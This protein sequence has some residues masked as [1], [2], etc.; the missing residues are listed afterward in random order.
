MQPGIRL[1]Q[2]L[3]F[4]EKFILICL[5]FMIPLGFTSYYLLHD[6][7]QQ[8][9][10]MQQRQIGLAYIEAT[11]PLLEL[12]P[13]HRG[14]I[15]GLLHGHDA[16]GSNLAAITPRL[17]QALVM[18]DDA[19]QRWAEKLGVTDA[20]N[21][22]RNHWIHLQHNSTTLNADQS[23]QQH[24][25]L[26]V[27]YMRLLSR[28]VV[29]STLFTTEDAIS[30]HLV[31][32]NF[33]HLPQLIESL[34]QLR[35][36]GS[37]V[38]SDPQITM[39][40]SEQLRL[41]RNAVQYNV[42]EVDQQ[43]LFYSELNFNP[44]LA[45]KE[46]KL[47]MLN[48]EYLQWIT[49]HNTPE[50]LQH[51]AAKEYF[52]L[53]TAFISSGY[54]L[55]HASS[56]ELQDVFNAKSRYIAQRAWWLKILLITVLLI[57]IYLVS[58]FFI[59]TRKT[60]RQLAFVVSQLQQHKVP[61][62]SHHP[63][64]DELSEIVGMFNTLSFQLIHK[65]EEDTLMAEIS[66]L[67]LRSHSLATLC[68][69][70][71]VLLMGSRSCLGATDPSHLQLLRSSGNRYIAAATYHNATVLTVPD[72]TPQ[73]YQLSFGD[74]PMI[75]IPLMDGQ[76]R[77]GELVL[78]LDT[79]D[80][81]KR[82]HQLFERI[83]NALV[84]AITR[85]QTDHALQRRE[86]AL[87]RSN[88]ELER[89]ASIASHDLQEPLRKIC[90]FG[91]RLLYRANLEGRNLDFL[92]RM[93]D[94]AG[95]MQLLIQDLLA[96]SRIQASTRPFCKVDLHQIAQQ[97]VDNLLVAIQECGATI[98]IDP[99]PTLDGD[100]VQLEQLLQNLIGNAIKYRHQDVAP[101]IHLKCIQEKILDNGEGL[102]LLA[103]QDNGI[104]FEQK[105]ANQIFEAFKRLHGR[106]EYSGSGIGLALCR[107]IVERHGGTV[108]AT[109]VPDE[110]TCIHFS[111]Q[112]KHKQE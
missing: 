70:I 33:H 61:S 27:E 2:Q 10:S 49:Q 4:A 22:I 44:T 67:A 102:L 50:K 36:I 97:A 21:T 75:C 87:S 80:S 58:A 72:P 57:I 3:R 18:A 12:I 25:D 78:T 84:I 62:L 37:G 63:G 42:S 93:V 64:R 46:Q 19:N 15:N 68:D 17:Q 20:W 101:Q 60:T 95:R 14:L 24:T 89:F 40:E 39:Q 9:V 56:A 108:H 54:D 23:W 11:S 1:M 53:G 59:S 99:L 31:A 112:I 106:T 6:I 35:G 28:V 26:V 8:T 32:L 103:C 48:Q 88:E 13:Q 52:N 85:L 111:L 109:S 55:L 51:N 82:N 38:L 79:I 92:T 16:F 47:Q 110:G 98:S 34:G 30:R 83:A 7:H 41:L 81:L 74:H 90:S 105:Y 96:F 45:E 29:A 94:A 77:L 86:Q 43:W 104:G 65:H 76:R 107:R 71:L 5:L 69:H 91:D 66:H 100:P 73:I